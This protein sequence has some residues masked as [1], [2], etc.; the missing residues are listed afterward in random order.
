MAFPANWT[1]MH[2]V[3]E[4]SGPQFNAAYW[5]ERRMD[6]AVSSQSGGRI[7]G[8]LSPS[9]D[10]RTHQLSPPTRPLEQRQFGGNRRCLGDRDRT[11]VLWVGSRL[12]FA[13]PQ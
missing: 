4:L 9:V 10:G 7:I 2:V 6:A 11:T 13:A 5:R 1:L 8:S 3:D 12:L